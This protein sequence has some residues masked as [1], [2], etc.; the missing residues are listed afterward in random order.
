M[1]CVCHL[2]GATLYAGCGFTGE[3]YTLPNAEGAFNILS[4]VAPALSGQVS[5]VRV[6][7][8]TIVGLKASTTPVGPTEAWEFASVDYC[9]PYY[10]SWD[11]QTK[12]AAFYKTNN[13]FRGSGKT[14]TFPALCTTAEHIV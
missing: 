8:G 2:A 3:S 14:T 1:C 7:P 4:Q 9:D 11:N 10:S 5:S 13:L 6:A 12:S